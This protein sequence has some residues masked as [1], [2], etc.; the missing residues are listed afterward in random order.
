M[1]E[2]LTCQLLAGESL[3]PEQVRAA[4]DRLVDEQ[5]SAETKADFLAALARKGETPEEITGFARELRARAVVPPVDPEW[6]RGRVILDVVG[7][8]GDRAGTFNISTAVALLCAAAGVPVAKHG[9]RAVT[10]RAGSAD[11]LEALGIPIQLSPA[12]AARSLQTRGFAF[13]FAP[14]YHP[15][16]RQIAPARRLCAERGQR[17]IFNYLGPLL[18]P[19]VPDAQLMGVPRPDMCTPLARVLQSLGIRRGLVVCGGIAD[20]AGST[21]YLDEISTAGA[22]TVASFGLGES[23]TCVVWERAPRPLSPVSLEDL[24]GGDAAGNAALLEGLL[25]GQDQGPRR[26]AVLYNAAAALWVAGAAASVAEGWALAERVLA[27]GRAA[28]K[29]EELRRG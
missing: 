19:V 4:V 14:L 28:R 2:E 8:G 18:N 26:E 29:L 17:T 25:R 24:R 12:D 3:G 6:R 10:S 20:A 9:N 15:A 16:F 7:T 27:E 23:A 21:V 22:N 1:L 5:V 11:V 13:F